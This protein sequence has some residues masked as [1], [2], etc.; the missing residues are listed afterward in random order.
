MYLAGTNRRYYLSVTIANILIGGLFW[1]ITRPAPTTHIPIEVAQS[2]PITRTSDADTGIKGLP[3]HLTIASIQ[4]SLDVSPGTFD[5][6]DQTWTTNDSDAFFATNSVLANSS[7]GT[8]LLYGHARWGV[9]GALPDLRLGDEAT[10]STNSGYRFTYRYVS[11]RDVLPTDTSVF[12]AN[13]PATLI[14]QTCSGAWDAYRSLY[15][16]RLISEAA[17]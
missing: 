3:T 17:A 9:F 6:T 13:G 7:T 14:L 1:L 15:S 16:F 12:T 4:V 8:T 10:V 5:P 11:K 2:L